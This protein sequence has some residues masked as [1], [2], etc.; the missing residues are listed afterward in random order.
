[1]SGQS[2][3]NP[4]PDEPHLRRAV[5]VVRFEGGGRRPERRDLVEDGLPLDLR[6]AG[7]RVAAVSA[8]E[9]T[10][11]MFMFHHFISNPLLCHANENGRTSQLA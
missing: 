10:H 3:R 5:V 9:K 2:G 8:Y 4:A 7:R 6:V 1:M 11:S